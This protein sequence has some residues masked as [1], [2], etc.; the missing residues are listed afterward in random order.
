M[1]RVLTKFDEY[2]RH[3]IGNT[4]DS[5]VD[6]SQYWSD[7]YYFTMGD[8]A[9]RVAWFMGL[10]LHVNNDVI[11]GFTCTALDGRQ[12]NMRWSRRLRPAIDDI[13]VGPMKV[14]VIEGLRKLRVTCEANEY[15]QAYDLMWEG[16]TPPFNE[17]HV[18][19]Y[20]NGRLHSDRSNY[21]QVMTVNGWIEVAGERIAVDNW[22]GVRDHSWGIGNQTGGPRTTVIAP[23]LQVAAPPGLRQWCWFKLPDRCIFWQFHHAG[24]KNPYTK[25]ETRCQFPYGDERESFTYVGLDYDVEF[26]QVDGRNTRRMKTTTVRLTRPDGGVESYR[27]EP[28]SYPLYLQGGGYHNGFNDTLGR[29]VYRGDFHHEGEVWEIDRITNIQT[30]TPVELNRWHYAEAWGRGTSLDDANDTGTGHL[31]SVVLGPYEGLR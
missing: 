13:E 11:D 2:P 7:G 31:E 8:D 30:P 16:V 25:L 29:G 28:I 1:E 5:V 22:T 3:Q 23:P 9:G 24:A 27:I 21:D 19:V 26:E 12:H 14:E 20:V 17:D 18:Q 10:R 15:G 6:G 4:F